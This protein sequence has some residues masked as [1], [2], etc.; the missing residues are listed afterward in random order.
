MKHCMID[1]ETLDT[2]EDA[3]VT[4]IGAVI[5]DPAKGETI[6]S[7]YK[8]LNVNNQ[9]TI[10]NRTIKIDTIKFHLRN[11]KMISELKSALEKTGSNIHSLNEFVDFVKD[12][13]YFWANGINFDFP[14]LDSLLDNHGIVSPWGY[15][16]QDMRSL[17]LLFP[18]IR[19]ENSNAHNALSDAQAQADFVS[20]CFKQVEKL[21][22]R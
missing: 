16:L 4:S 18:S 1:I 5:F 20:K 12:V 11:E 15:R 21:N 22:E 10:F 17:R 19:I 13:N 7:F 3:V 6:D 2:S 9:F 8:V 14:I